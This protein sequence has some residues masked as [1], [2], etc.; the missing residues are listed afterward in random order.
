[1]IGALF[2]LLP[3]SMPDAV[4][5]QGGPPAAE[6]TKVA[7]LLKDFPDADQTAALLVFAT[8]DGPQREVLTGPQRAAVD[9]RATALAGYSTVPQAVRPRFST[10][11]TTALITVPVRAQSGTTAIV[12]QADSL[13][14]TARQGLPGGLRAWLTGPVGF[15]G[16]T[17]TAF[18]GADVRLLVITA[19]VVAVLL[20]VTYRSPVLWTVPL[21]V[22]AVADGLA[23]FVVAALA[24][25]YGLS[26]D[27]SILGILSV[28][29]FGAGTNYALLLIA[30]YREELLAEPDTR[31]AMR[32]AVVAAGPAIVASAGTV[33]LSLLML[34]FATLAGNRALGAACSIGIV[35]ALLMVLGVLPAA[36]VVCGRK[37]FW[38][39]IPHYLEPEDRGE[40]GHA[41]W[42]RIG[43]AVQRRPWQIGGAAV[44]LIVLLSAG[45]SG[46]TIGL[47]QTDQ[48]VGHPE[49]VR[50]QHL[51][52]ETF[53]AESGPQ[54]VVLAH[55]ADAA[56]AVGIAES[57]EGVRS[58]RVAGN[59]NGWTKIDVAAAGTPQSD[60]AFA[61]VKALRAAY[62]SRGHALVGGPDAAA[63]DQHDAAARDRVVIIPLILT[64]VAVVLLVLLRSLVAPLCLIV[65]VIATYVASLGCGNWLFQHVFGFRAFDT[66]VLLYAFLF[67]VA[68]GVDYNIF[69]ATRAREQRLDLGAREAMRYA[70]TRTGGVITSA[71]ILLA[72]VFVVLGVLPV[73]ALAQIG[74]IVCIGVLLDTLVVRTLLVPALASV[75]GER[76]WWPAARAATRSTS[77]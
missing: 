36:L 21:A 15:Q 9:Q 41:I 75:L 10:D 4:P 35:I 62:A 5:P 45:L 16:D 23:R 33:A 61:T 71:G 3:K 50:A 67:L 20:I 39:F 57:V 1:M 25:S 49:S 26:V 72:A 30:R 42:G 13:R 77:H 46:A 18:A 69:L 60:A 48:F 8:S 54:L 66:P 74:T 31:R 47:S 37:V 11:G 76:F 44:L 27:A 2:A 7:A 32:T 55:D 14:Q 64:V 12:N 65:T 29:V 19:S 24:D 52:A 17:I 38:P 51:V 40:G 53:P 59:A 28:L 63:L 56:D 73:V 43:S 22:V 68:L 70:L 58:A 34:L 6:S